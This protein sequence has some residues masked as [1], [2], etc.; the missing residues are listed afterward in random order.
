MKAHCIGSTVRSLSRKRSQRYGDVLPPS[1]RE[2]TQCIL[3]K[4]SR[5]LDGSPLLLA[6]STLLPGSDARTQCGVETVHT[7]Q[8]TGWQLLAQLQGE[9]V[10]DSRA[11]DV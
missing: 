8:R 10:Q 6:V 7:F 1:G 5:P 11:G 4:Q 2:G 9:V 3:F